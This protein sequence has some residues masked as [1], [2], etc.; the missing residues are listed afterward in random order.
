MSTLFHIATASQFLSQTVLSKISFGEYSARLLSLEEKKD[1]GEDSHI[2]QTAKY[3]HRPIQ[4]TEIYQFRFWT[5]VT[6]QQA[7]YSVDV[8]AEYTLHTGK[9]GTIELAEDVATELFEQSVKFTLWPYVRIALQDLS[10]KVEQKPLLL[11]LMIQDS[12]PKFP[13][14]K[15]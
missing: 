2:R 5:K 6:T 15:I 13:R 7:K 4:G 1:N 12:A 10:M 3:S 11:G 8:G 9:Q 14:D